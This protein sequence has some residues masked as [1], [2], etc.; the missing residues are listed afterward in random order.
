MH[1]KRT[2]GARGTPASASSSGDPRAIHQAWSVK[3]APS[4]RTFLASPGARPHHRGPGPTLTSDTAHPKQHGVEVL[5]AVDLAAARAVRRLELGRPGRG[6]AARRAAA[7]SKCR[8][9]NARARLLRLLRARLAALGSSALPGRGRTTGCPATALDAR[10]SHLQP[11][12]YPPLTTQVQ[13][14]FYLEHPD[15]SSLTPEQVQALRAQLSITI[16]GDA[17]RCPNPVGSFV[18]APPPSPPPPSPP[19]PSP[20]PTPAP[21]HHHSHPSTVA[22]TSLAPTSLA[23]TVT[24]TTFTATTLTATSFAQASFPQY[25]LDA[26]LKVG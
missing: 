5:Q 7:R 18:Q 14:D 19:P 21:P 22:R 3:R 11:P 15:V 16:H 1:F 26:L 23:T 2:T 24:A 17:A 13:R 10:A 6:A 4:W 12:A 20:P 9:G 25:I 8:L